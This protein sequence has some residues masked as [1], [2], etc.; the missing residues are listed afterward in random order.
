MEDDNR[1]RKCYS[2]EQFCQGAGAD[3]IGFAAVCRVEAI[4]PH[5]EERENI[6]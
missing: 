1:A 4:S 2:W 5:E 6:R 3:R